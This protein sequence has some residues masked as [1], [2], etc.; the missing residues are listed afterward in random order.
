M[1]CLIFVV[2]LDAF[3]VNVVAPFLGYNVG[4]VVM[5]HTSKW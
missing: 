3:L 1:F 4:V 5:L 2:F